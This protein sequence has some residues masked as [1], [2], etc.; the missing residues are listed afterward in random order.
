MCACGRDETVNFPKN[1]APTP[2]RIYIFS[3][4]GWLGGMRLPLCR[5][6]ALSFNDVTIQRNK[7]F[8]TQKHRNTEFFPF[9][10]TNILSLCLRVFVS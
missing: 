2:T 6:F 1:L 10:V 5:I 3:H 8:R 4:I 7:L 9:V